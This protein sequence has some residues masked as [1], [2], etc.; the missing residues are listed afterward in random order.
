MK[1]TPLRVPEPSTRPGDAS[2]TGRDRGAVEALKAALSRRF[3]GMVESIGAADVVEGTARPGRA[4]ELR[5]GSITEVVGLPGEG[6]TT[7]VLEGMAQVLG[8]RPRRFA[9]WLDLEGTFYPPAAA[10]LGVPLERLLLVRTADLATGLA[11]VELSL[12]GGAV[13][14]AA[15]DVPASVQPL[16]LSLYHRL[17][18]RVRESGGVLVV[19]S[20]HSI[21]PA[22]QR[23]LLG[24]GRPSGSVVDSPLHIPASGG[25]ASM[26][27]L[28]GA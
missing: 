28:S 5:D 18:R 16:R 27:S 23:V 1:L 20:R 3:P 24:D 25:R 19:L 9:L 14:M 11:A 7:R 13:C 26:R 22:D 10:Q 21:I 2:S 8:R 17:R 6:G 12:R 15:V 4:A